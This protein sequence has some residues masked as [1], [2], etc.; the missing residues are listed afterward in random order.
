MDDPRLQALVALY[1]AENPDT[2]EVRAMADAY[3]A[4]ALKAA[5]AIDA[6]VPLPPPSIAA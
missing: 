6:R 4:V 5:Q 1:V 3:L 2:P